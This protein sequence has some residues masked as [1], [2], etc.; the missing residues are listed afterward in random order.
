[1]H[2]KST[3]T[4]TFHISELENMIFCAD[5]RLPDGKDPDPSLNWRNIKSGKEHVLRNLSI[6]F[7]ICST[8]AS[9]LHHPDHL[10]LRD[11][12][13]VEHTRTSA[14]YWTECASQEIYL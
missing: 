5:A 9:I 11:N 4:K 10:A 6:L 7:E 2:S 1:M 12:T 13:A 14:K 3:K 8:G